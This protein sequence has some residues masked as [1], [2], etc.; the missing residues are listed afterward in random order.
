MNAAVSAVV[1]DVVSK[2]MSK[3]D[4]ETLAILAN[5]NEIKF[6]LSKDLEIIIKRK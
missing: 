1:R 6:D 3:N 2:S 4:I 5:A